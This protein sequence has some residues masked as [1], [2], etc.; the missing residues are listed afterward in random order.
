MRDDLAPPSFAEPVDPAA[1]L[2]NCCSNLPVPVNCCVDIRLLK[3]DCLGRLRD[4]VELEL[5]CRNGLRGEILLSLNPDNTPPPPLRPVLSKL[6]I[7]EPRSANGCKN[8][9]D[10]DRPLF[11]RGLPISKESCRSCLSSSSSCSSSVNLLAAVFVS[12]IVLPVLVLC[13]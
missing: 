11:R 8:V 13:S 7:G 3:K 9:T 6:R 10:W 2:K 5:F 1:P 4:W 12:V